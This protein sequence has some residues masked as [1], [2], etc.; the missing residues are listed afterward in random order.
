VSITPT[1]AWGHLVPDDDRWDRLIAGLRA[2]DKDASREVCALYGESLERIAAR[3]LPGA[4]RAR[5]GPED[6][7][8]SVCRTFFRRARG[9]EFQL[10][11]TEALWR[12]LCAITLTKVRA[13]ARHHLRQKRGLDRE[14]D[15]ADEGAAVAAPGPT[16]A[17]AAEFAD[18]FQHLLSGLDAEAQAVVDLKLQDFT[19][20]EI[21]DRL[22]CSER[23][24]RRVLKRLQDHLAAGL[25]RP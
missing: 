9:G 22:G 13:Q 11:D 24:V 21:A 18:Q 10:A 2:G 1:R 8:Q 4:L 14:T 3:R 7:V 23:T 17:Q 25:D 19:Q 6:V 12:L 20:A 5:V 15:A 16:P